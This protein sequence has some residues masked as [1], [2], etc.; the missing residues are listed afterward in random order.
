MHRLG[1]LVCI[2]LCFLP[3]FSQSK[4]D[5]RKLKSKH[6]AVQLPHRVNPQPHAGLPGEVEY[7]VDLTDQ[8][9]SEE[10]S[11]P[12]KAARDEEK[13]ETGDSFVSR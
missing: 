1:L 4:Q 8:Q 9:R 3:P 12:V 6:Q 10:R 2:L 7:E 5:L 13:A 11:K